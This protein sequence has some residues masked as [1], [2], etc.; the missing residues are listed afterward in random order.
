MLKIVVVMFK[1]NSTLNLIIL[2]NLNIEEN[3]KIYFW[4]LKTDLTNLM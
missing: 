1:E 4:P 3:L 2:F